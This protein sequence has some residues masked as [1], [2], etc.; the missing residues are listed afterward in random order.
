MV[1][2]A[3]R[4]SSKYGNKVS[5]DVT[6]NRI[7]AQAGNMKSNFTA[8][9]AAS[10]AVEQDTKTLLTGWGVSVALI[11]SYLSFSRE[12]MGIGNTHEGTVAENEACLATKKW[13]DALRGLN[14]YYLQKIALDVHNYDVGACT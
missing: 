4:R 6:K 14:K 10:V 2:S 1:V 8:S 13:G 11:P 7:D 5:G 9:A 3:D 12:L